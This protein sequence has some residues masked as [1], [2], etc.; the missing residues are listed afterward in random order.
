MALDPGLSHSAFRLASI[1]M[2]FEGDR[3]C[4]PSQARLARDLCLSVD[5]VQRYIRELELYGFLTREKRRGF[6][7]RYRLAPLYEAPVRHGSI[8]ETGD[9]EV[10]N[11]SP[12]RP[13]APRT[14]RARRQ[15]AAS[16]AKP[17]SPVRSLKQKRER[18]DSRVGEAPVQHV[19]LAAPVRLAEKR[20]EQKPIQVAAPERPAEGAPVRLAEPH[21]CGTNK[22]DVTYNQ[23][24]QESRGEALSGGGECKEMTGLAAL[25]R[26][27]VNISRRELG[28]HEARGRHLN[29]AE[30]NDWASWLVTSRERSIANKPAFAATKVR[31][32]CTVD[33]IFRHSDLSAQPLL[34]SQRPQALDAQ[35]QSEAQVRI[36]RADRA[37]DELSAS[38]RAT[39]RANAL[40]DGAVWIARDG[41]AAVFELLVRAAERRLVL[42][43]MA[44][45]V[46]AK[47]YG[48]R[49]VSELRQST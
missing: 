15:V 40:N 48:N 38:E 44:P 4:F 18:G 13:P 17:L 42:G 16:P 9:L 45:A 43:E 37:I 29:D 49:D 35:E 10:E 39:L 30:L 28:I 12:R 23:Q 24:Q 46:I 26:A 8:E 22:N 19:D 14:L 7:N 47:D 34:D 11:I 6:P 3:G 41:S 1:L 36:E 5:S 21:G 25:Q 2:H 32:G 31:M 33:D 27:G 20:R